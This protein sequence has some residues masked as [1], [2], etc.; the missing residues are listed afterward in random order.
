VVEDETSMVGLANAFLSGTTIE[1]KADGTYALTAMGKT[2]AGTWSTNGS[3]VTINGKTTETGDDTFAD[4]SS[5]TVAGDVLTI[6]SNELDVKDDDD[7]DEP[8]YREQGFT[9][10]ETKLVF[11]K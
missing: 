4:G 7:E 5:V 3:S 2:K 10:Y 11:K 6:I 1:F 8:T 9:K